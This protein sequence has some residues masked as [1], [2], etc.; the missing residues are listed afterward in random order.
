VIEQTQVFTGMHAFAFDRRWFSFEYA[1][2]KIDAASNNYTIHVSNVGVGDAGDSFNVNTNQLM[3][4]MRFSSVD[5]D[6]DNNQYYNCA[7][8]TG[9]GWWFNSCSYGNLNGDLSTG[10]YYWRSLTDFSLSPTTQLMT[11]RM[12]IVSV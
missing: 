7:S 2:F 9:G 8:V 6:N 12:M 5:K 3:N 1:T 4:G 10:Y 11:S